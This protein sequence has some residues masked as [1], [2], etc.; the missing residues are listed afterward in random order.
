MVVSW[1]SFIV[2][3]EVVPGKMI[4]ELKR[5]LLKTHNKNY[6]KYLMISNRVVEVNSE[7]G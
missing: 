2:P 4:K 5:I 3:P 6:V 7:S 1:I